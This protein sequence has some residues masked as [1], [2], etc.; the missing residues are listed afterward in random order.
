LE[1]STDILPE[2]RDKMPFSRSDES[3]AFP[4]SCGFLSLR[5]REQIHDGVNSTNEKA[6][7]LCVGVWLHV[8]SPFDR[9]VGSVRAASRGTDDEKRGLATTDR[10]RQRAAPQLV[11]CW[12]FDGN[13]SAVQ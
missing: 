10:R 4:V 9:I 11:S 5:V 3:C 12:W 13:D 8:F 2:V 6:D 7:C 1:R